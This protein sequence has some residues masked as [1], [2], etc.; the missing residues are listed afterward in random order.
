MQWIGRKYLILR[1]FWFIL[2]Y[3]LCNLTHFAIFK[4]SIF[5]RKSYLFFEKLLKTLWKASIYTCA[6]LKLFK[7][8]TAKVYFLPCPHNSVTLRRK[9]HCCQFLGHILLGI[10]HELKHTLIIIQH[11]WSYITCMVLCLAF[12]LN[13]IGKSVHKLKKIRSASGV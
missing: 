5:Y 1:C 13:I 7:T 12:S 9:A 8:I 10:M 4:M 3:I 6:K 2:V 11:S